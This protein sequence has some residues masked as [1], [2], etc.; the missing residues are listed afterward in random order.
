MA[1]AAT[2]GLDSAQ[3]ACQELFHEAEKMIPTTQKRSAQPSRYWGSGKV[4]MRVP[5]Q[6][7]FAELSFT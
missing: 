3:D 1:G 6:G 7:I 5:R 2:G 4:Y